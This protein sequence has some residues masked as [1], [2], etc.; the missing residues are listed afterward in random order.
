MY[1]ERPNEWRGGGG[2]TYRERRK[3]RRGRIYGEDDSREF[4]YMQSV[5]LDALIILAVLCYVVYC[6]LLVT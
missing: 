1:R 4:L 2:G 6:T 5:S 3:E